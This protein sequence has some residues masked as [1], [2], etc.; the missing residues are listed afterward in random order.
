MSVERYR[1]KE[2]WKE[3]QRGKEERGRKEASRIYRC[4]LFTG[5]SLEES[6]FIFNHKSDS[7]RIT[8]SSNHCSQF[9]PKTCP[10]CALWLMTYLIPEMFPS[11]FPTVNNLSIF[12]DQ[13]QRY[14]FPEMFQHVPK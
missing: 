14:L 10:I 13:F 2:D 6:I 8:V 4:H 5:G 11:S 7:K 1:D 9:A 3:R 12:L